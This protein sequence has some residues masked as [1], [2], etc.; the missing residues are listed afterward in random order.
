MQELTIAVEGH[1]C[2]RVWRLVLLVMVQE[3]TVRRFRDRA[4][5]KV[6]VLQVQWEV[7]STER[8]FNGLE[9][10]SFWDTVDVR[11]IVVGREV[12]RQGW[13]EVSRRRSG[14]A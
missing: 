4:A 3:G 2:V 9:V 13:I 14:I 5:M 12:R 6:L 10:R 1:W 11:W 8:L 7:W